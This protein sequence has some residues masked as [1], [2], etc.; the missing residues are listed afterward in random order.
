MRNPFK[1]FLDLMRGGIA[2]Q[3]TQ[4]IP[5]GTGNTRIIDSRGDMVFTTCIE[6]LSK[7]LAQTRW[8]LYGGDN[9][10]LTGLMKQ[11]SFI[12][13]Q[14]PYP[15]I[16]A[17]DFWGYME[18]QRL[19]TG[20]AVAYLDFDKLGRLQHVVPLDGSHVSIYWDNNNI[21]GGARKLIYEYM[22]NVSGQTFTMFPEE[23][24]HVKAFSANGIVGRPAVNVLRDTLR[25]NAE[26]EYS[27]RRAVEKGFHGTI[28]LQYTSDLSFKKQTEL[29]ESVLK[30]LARGENSVLPLP[31]GMSAMN[32]ANDIKPYYDVL[33]QANAQAISSF[34]GI[35]L[36]M[37]N[38]GGGSGMATFSS[39]QITQYYNL[40]VA[41]IV[42]AYANEL[43]V[44]LLTRVQLNKGYTFDS[45]SDA[46]DFLDAQTKAS[47]LCSY[48]NAGILSAD[49]A[50]TSLKYSTRGGEADELNS[51]NVA[52]SGTLG[53]SSGNEGG[54]G[55]KGDNA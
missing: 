4:Y 10:E 33:K 49:E 26:V 55:K 38:I 11:F 34:F 32:L 45:A 5:I 52:K 15:G 37:L 46:F 21:F 36:V 18:K 20:N 8:S 48:K 9:D 42:Q 22:D 47:V 54:R 6:I 3:R 27:L 29:Q 40:T 31:V 17:F 16:N 44:K 12:L 28:I 14:Q 53:D 35:P 1:K 2:N 23:V 51:A 25:C 30:L 39:N 24:L 41:P 43:S 50:R 19:S 13:N 7:Q